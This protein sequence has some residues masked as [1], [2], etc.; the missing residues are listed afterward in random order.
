MRGEDF[1]LPPKSTFAS[2]TPP[3][4]W[5]R[6][7]DGKGKEVAGGNT[8]TCV[9]KTSLPF[10]FGGI[11][12]K[13]PH[14][15]GEDSGPL[16]R[17]SPCP[18]PPP[19]AWGRRKHRTSDLQEARNTPTCVGKT[20]LPDIR[21]K[22]PEK[23][24]HMRGEDEGLVHTPARNRETP[25]HAWGRPP[26]KRINHVHFRNT[27]TCVGKTQRAKRV[28][29]QPEKHPHMRGEDHRDSAGRGRGTET[30]P[31]AWGRQH[32]PFP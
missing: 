12:K 18:E 7:A 19:H 15:R 6:H 9:G 26:K 8:P 16:P 17:H 20:T 32:W 10:P 25:P 3:H 28:D 2:E 22:C 5:G 21:L 14:M 23:H 27:P 30:P 13:H 1:I 11:Y 24:P 31:H 4:A 29:R